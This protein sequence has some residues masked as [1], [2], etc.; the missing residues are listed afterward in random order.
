[1]AKTTLRTLLLTIGMAIVL[2]MSASAQSGRVAGK[3]ILR[4]APQSFL[5][6][7]LLDLEGTV[8][9][10]RLTDELGAFEFPVLEPGRYRLRVSIEDFTRTVTVSVAPGTQKVLEL[11]M[12]PPTDEPSA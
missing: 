11:D 2:F 6:V 9:N 12:T 4:G 10:G 1:M 7:R 5:E 3:V 8:V